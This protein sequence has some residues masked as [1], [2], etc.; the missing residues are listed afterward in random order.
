MKEKNPSFEGKIDQR[1]EFTKLLSES[2]LHLKEL[3]TKVSQIDLTEITDIDSDI[4]I[5]WLVLNISDLTKSKECV[6]FVYLSLDRLYTATD[7]TLYVY[8]IR[9][10]KSPIA[11]YK[12]EGECYSGIIA[13]NHLY[14]G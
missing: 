9:E 10:H 3:P 7:E 5:D 12:L 4:D 13:Y 1:F 14:L 8:L 2:L 11:T 6:Y